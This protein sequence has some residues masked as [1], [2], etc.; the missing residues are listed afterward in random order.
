MMIYDGFAL[1]VGEVGRSSDNDATETEFNF[2]EIL[3]C[4]NSSF[5]SLKEEHDYLFD[6][7]V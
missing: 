2:V 1:S 6:D 5:D 4:E 3:A 7:V